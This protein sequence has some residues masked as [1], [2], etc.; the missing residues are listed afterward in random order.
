MSALPARPPGVS[1][2]VS[3]SL[4]VLGERWT[5]L[6]VR[7]ALSGVTT[8]EAFRESLGLG[9]DVLTERLATLVDYG[10]LEKRSYQQAGARTRHEYHLT[11][12]GRQLHVI[13][14]GLQMWGDAHLPWPSGPS[15]ERLDRRTGEPVRVAFV[16]RDGRQLPDERIDVVHHGGYPSR[17]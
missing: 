6:I 5:L 14:G 1:C 8:F 11:D 7:D 10:V 4:A 3:R 15:T 12:A 13:V 17:T 9:A 16:D 2:A